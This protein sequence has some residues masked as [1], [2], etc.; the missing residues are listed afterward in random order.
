MLMEER[1][2]LVP[3]VERLLGAI[4]GARGV[5]KSVAG[6]VVAVKLVALA[7][8]P[9]QRFTS[10]QGSLTRPNLAV[11]EVLQDESAWLAGAAAGLL[12]KT[13]V[14][15]HMSGLRVRPGLKARAAFAAGLAFNGA[16]LMLN[17]AFF[18]LQNA[19]IPTAVALAN[20]ALNAAL[21]AAFYRLGIWGIPLATSIV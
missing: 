3:A 15:G 17:R 19:W 10:I 14:V 5:E 6:A 16:M 20:L 21:D 8:L 13:N 18:S 9:E 12:T 2:D 7:E 1:E 4:G 11:Y